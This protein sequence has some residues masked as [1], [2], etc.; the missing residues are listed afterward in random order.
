MT[1]RCSGQTKQYSVH[2]KQKVD[3]SRLSSQSIGKL[4]FFSFAELDAG[5]KVPSVGDENF[6]RVL[7]RMFY[8]SA[9]C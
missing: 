8:T 7:S 3:E 5:A 6:S 4:L 9:E 2:T 1:N